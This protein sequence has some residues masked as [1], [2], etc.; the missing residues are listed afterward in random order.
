MC[1]FL[2]CALKIIKGI[3]HRK[4]LEGLHSLLPQIV[5]LGNERLNL[6]KSKKLFNFKNGT[7]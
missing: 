7:G 3:S 5:K 4:I 6:K 2:F 1:G